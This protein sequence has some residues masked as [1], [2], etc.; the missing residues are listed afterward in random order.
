MENKVYWYNCEKYDEKLITEAY[1]EILVDNGLLDFVT[2]GMKIGIKV[3]LVGNFGPDKAATTHPKAT[4]EIDG[5]IAMIEPLIDK[6]HAYEKNGTVY[7]KTRSFDG[8]GK[9]S[10]KN[11][12][13]LEAGHRDIKVV[14][15][16]EKNDPLDF[17]LWKPKKEGEI[18]WNSP[19]GEGRPG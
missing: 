10:K 11:I 15:T 5:M 1:Q 2:S 14:G 13:D 17:V 8:Y 16:D 12:D 6:G 7:F 9:L 4:E 18:A 19:W 3:N